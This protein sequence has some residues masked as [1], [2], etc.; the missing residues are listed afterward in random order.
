MIPA[1]LYA[2]I[3]ASALGTKALPPTCEKLKGRQFLILH[4]C[5]QREDVRPTSDQC[6]TAM[7]LAVDCYLDRYP[8]T[9]R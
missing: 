1:N 4:E 2:A 9:A 7:R 3:V 8:D 5:L 6:E